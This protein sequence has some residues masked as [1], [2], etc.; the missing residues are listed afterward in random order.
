MITTTTREIVYD[1]ESRD[2]AMYLNGELVG[3]ARTHHDAEVTIDELVHSTLTHAAPEP[4][5]VTDTSDLNARPIPRCADCGAALGDYGRCEDC[6]DRKYAAECKP[7]V[8]GNYWAVCGAPC[9]W[10]CMC[11]AIVRA[12][13]AETPRYTIACSRCGQPASILE[14]HGAFCGPC[15]KEGAEYEH[16]QGRWRDAES[17]EPWAAGVNWGS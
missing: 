7:D 16:D 11:D 13:I 10:P 14:A 17:E 2:F 6:D 1:K 3:F 4:A 15:H 5:P 8:Q 9:D 12:P